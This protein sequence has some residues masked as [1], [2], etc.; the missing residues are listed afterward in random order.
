MTVG[1][2][3]M[4]LFL[5][6]SS[7]LVLEK[8]MNSYFDVTSQ[9]FTLVIR[10]AIVLA[11]SVLLVSMATGQ[12]GISNYRELLNS[13]EQLARVNMNLSIENQ[14]LEDKIAKLK[15]SHDAQV[16]YLKENFGY[17]A[18]GEVIFRFAKHSS[19]RVSDLCPTQMGVDGALENC[20]VRARRF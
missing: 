10:W 8:L 18:Q 9:N 7:E 14:L 15:N 1:E 12:Y 4:L 20:R 19:T 13:K 5:M 11:L 16:H 2:F 3:S 6:S 17:I